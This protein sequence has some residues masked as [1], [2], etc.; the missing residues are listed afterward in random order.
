MMEKRDW[1]NFAEVKELVSTYIKNIPDAHYA[2]IF[3]SKLADGEDEETKN[4][5]GA[6]KMLC[7]CGK[8]L[9][10]TQWEFFIIECLL[11]QTQEA[12]KVQRTHPL[13]DLTQVSV[14]EDQ[15][16]FMQITIATK[17]FDYF[18]EK[19]KPRDAMLWALLTLYYK[20]R[21]KYPKLD[22]VDFTELDKLAEKHRFGSSHPVFT[23]DLDLD[24]DAI[25]R[26]ES[27]P[28]PE[29]REG[30]DSEPE[31]RDAMAGPARMGSGRISLLN[32]LTNSK[33]TSGCETEG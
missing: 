32:G 28:V 23:A 1:G 24:A 19:K 33:S 15:E 26:T 9:S 29:D 31:R 5:A 11:D 8:E 13:H 21:G 30:E 27:S 10:S 16:A 3:A 14:K 7:I 6:V 22:K 25:P 17:A 18:F 20:V 12:A 2:L 4:A